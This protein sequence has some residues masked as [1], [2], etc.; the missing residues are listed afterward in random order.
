MVFDDTYE[1]EAWNRSDRTRVVMIFDLWNPFLSQAERA[2]LAELVVAMG[3]FRAGRRGALIAHASAAAFHT[4]AGAFRPGTAARRS[5]V[6]CP[7]KPGRRI[8][9]TSPATLRCG[10]SAS[11]A[12]RTTTWMVSCG[13][14]RTSP[15]Y[16]TCARSWRA[17]AWCGVAR[18][19]CAS[20]PAR[21]VP[22][23]A[24]INYHWFYRVRVHIP[25]VTRPEVL[26]HCGGET[27]H[28]RG[29][30]AWLFDNWR[31]H[32]V[33]NP[34]PD[35][36][37]HLVADTSGS[38]SFWQFVAQAAQPGVADRELRFDTARDGVRC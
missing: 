13:R 8:P 7:R 37:I 1:H 17:S 6:R 27:V 16:R 26:F 21:S 9:I 10:S 22:E 18:A 14:R 12:A 11:K 32:S 38:A 29:G 36:R 3:E 33:E 23:H 15:N 25:I 34:T 19:C 35:A 4:I 5:R 28:M 2:V 20:I 30:E 24:D 31:L